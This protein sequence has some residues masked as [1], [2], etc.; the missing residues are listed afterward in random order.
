MR[1]SESRPAR[2]PASRRSAL[3]VV[4]E[5]ADRQVIAS[6]LEAENFEVS[7]AGDSFEG[8][9]QYIRHP[10]KLV[11]ASLDLLRR[12]ET[13]LIRGVLRVSPDVK[14]LLLVP[15]GRR[16]SAAGHLEEGIS[17]LLCSP[18]CAAEVRLVARSLLSD[19]ASDPLTGLPNRA[20]AMRAFAREKG[21]VDRNPG[22]TT[23]GLGLLDLDDF[24]SINTQFSYREGDRVLRVATERLQ[25]FLR[26]TDV[27]TRWGGEEFVVL[28]NSLPAKESEARGRA[29]GILDRAR[30]NLGSTPISIPEGTRGTRRVTASGGLA[31]YPH[32][33]SN[34]EELFASAERCLKAAKAEKNRIVA[35]S[36]GGPVVTRVGSR[37]DPNRNDG[38]RGDRK[39]KL[40]G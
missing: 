11:I 26:L 20:A 4:R 35:V 14:I 30:E 22:K 7:Y 39:G 10:T 34:W 15:E 9:L 29:A 33:G 27:L 8:L 40:S 19:A 5:G 3:L 13:S 31:L 21:S 18:C 24:K 25:R 17:G 36:P 28:L 38:R 1:K 12:R 37:R 16:Q 32:D 6:A 2:V 23:L